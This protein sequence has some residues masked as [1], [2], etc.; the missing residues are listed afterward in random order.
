MSSC[1]GGITRQLQLSQV[2]L[3]LFYLEF[4]KLSLHIKLLSHTRTNTAKEIGILIVCMKSSYA[5]VINE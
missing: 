5:L 1:G 2:C 4:P 3:S